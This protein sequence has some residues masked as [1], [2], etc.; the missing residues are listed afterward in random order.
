MSHRPPPAG[1]SYAD[2]PS[3]DEL[4]AL[5][6]RIRRRDKGAL[7]R[8]HALVTPLVRAFHEG[9]VQG[10]RGDPCE[11]EARVSATL[12]RIYRERHSFGHQQPFRA[13]LLQVARD[14]QP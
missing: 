11:L 8:L 7:D 12:W 4:V 9:Q 5:M 13:W 10:G 2:R 3:N 14:D 1:V 6:A